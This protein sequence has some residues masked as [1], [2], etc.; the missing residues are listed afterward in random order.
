MYNRDEKSDYLTTTSCEELWSLDIT[1]LNT[2]GVS[3]RD[4][5]GGEYRK[6]NLLEITLYIVGLIVHSLFIYFALYTLYVVRNFDLDFI[7]DFIP[8]VF[9]MSMTIL[10]GS[11][12]WFYRHE[13]FTI[14]KEFNTRWI[15]TRTKVHL[16]NKINDLISTSKRVRYSYMIAI[17]II[18]LSYGLRSYVLLFTYY[19]KTV[20]LQSNGTMDFSIAFYPLTYPFTHQ[21]MNRYILLLM[22]E[23]CVNYF[24]VCYITCDTIFIQLMTHTSINFLVLADDFKNMNQHIDVCDNHSDCIQHFI[25]L[26]NQHRS[27]LSI[28]EKIESSYSMIAFFTMVL[29]GLDLCICILSLDKQLSEGNWELVTKNVVHAFAI[30]VQIIIYCNFSNTATEMTA[31]IQKSIYDSEWTSCSIKFKK[32]LFLMMTCTSEKYTFSAYGIIA[33]DREQMRTIFQ[34]TMSYFTLLR[35]FT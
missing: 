8:L 11:T 4:A 30:F 1:I 5:F 33:L 18:S 31:R 3:L 15:Y 27:M 16:L 9:G 6:S 32:L 26:V 23:Q 28:C 17:V 19:F 14:L 13:L 7:T 21:T 35:S 24:A 10:K 29:N 25:E 22:Y 34:T 12:L 20:V 2:V